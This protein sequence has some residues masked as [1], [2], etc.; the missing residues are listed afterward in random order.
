[1]LVLKAHGT[2]S[3]E[4]LR[5][6]SG[7]ASKLY[8]SSSSVRRPLQLPDEEGGFDPCPKAETLSLR[9][10]RME[11]KRRGERQGGRE[12][13]D[14]GAQERSG[15]SRGSPGG[16]SKGRGGGDSGAPGREEGVGQQEKEENE[17][18]ALFGSTGLDPREEI[19]RK[20]RREGETPGPQ[21]PNSEELIRIQLQQLFR[22]QFNGGGGSARGTLRP[23]VGASTNMAEIPRGSDIDHDFG[24]PEGDDAAAWGG[25]SRGRGSEPSSHGEPILPPT[26]DGEYGSPVAREALHWS[27][28][29]DLLLEGRAAS[30]MEVMTQLKSL[31]GLSK[32]MRPDLLRQLELLPLDRGGLATGRQKCRWQG[33]RRI[34]RRRS[35]R[36]PRTDHGRRGP[37]GRT[38]ERKESGKEG[39]GTA[40][41]SRELNEMDG[42][43]R[44]GWGATLVDTLLVSTFYISTC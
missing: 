25:P 6:L 26:P 19:R 3:E 36:S 2:T 38:K 32:S 21:G 27:A 1:M 23:S 15:R 30:A 42:S 18:E 16:S 20:L 29:L 35:F 8:T 11:Q 43:P 44:G 12:R 13:R 33:R 28:V 4:L 31:E 39:R 41:E 37:K 14:G 7:K 17:E 9:G 40:R 5:L 24:S 34:T 10:L 22:Q